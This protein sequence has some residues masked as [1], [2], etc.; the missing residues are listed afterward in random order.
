MS[1]GGVG[2]S[3]DSSARALSFVFRI[4]RLDTSAGADSNSH[5][6]MPV[7]QHI[8]V[9]QRS[10]NRQKDRLIAGHFGRIAL[11]HDGRLIGTYA[12]NREAYM[13]GCSKFGL[14]HFSLITIGDETAIDVGILG[15]CFNEH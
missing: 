5:T 9:D 15:M 2:L 8:E 13:D 7:P 12:S 6:T 3:N 10:Y 14:G 4:T 11:F 1:P